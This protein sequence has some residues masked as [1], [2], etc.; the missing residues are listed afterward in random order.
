MLHIHIL[1]YQRPVKRSI[2]KCETLR[3]KLLLFFYIIEM[4]TVFSFTPMS[5]LIFYQVRSLPA[6]ASFTGEKCR[7]DGGRCYIKYLLSS[8][9]PGHLLPENRQREKELVPFSFVIP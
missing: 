6:G 3:M 1:V 8:T 5:E 7:A 2:T 4:I 9:L